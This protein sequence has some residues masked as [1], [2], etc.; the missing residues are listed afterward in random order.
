MPGSVHGHA[1]QAREVGGRDPGRG[2]ADVAALRVE[3]E[4][5]PVEQ[6]RAR[7][8]RRRGD[9]GGASR[10]RADV[11]G[12]G[13]AARGEHAAETAASGKLSVREALTRSF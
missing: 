8:A 3:A 1:A 13:A 7:R 5:G 11:R 10:G 12:R 2:F 4:L 6:S 9:R